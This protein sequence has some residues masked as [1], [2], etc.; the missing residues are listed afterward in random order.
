[1]VTKK[2]RLLASVLT[3][4]L[5]MSAH[6]STVVTFED[7]SPNDLTDG[8]GG[9]LGWASLGGVGIAD[10]DLGGNGLKTFYG[11]EGMVSFD[12]S[13]VVF[14]GTYYKAYA[15]PQDEFPLT[16]IELWYQGKMVHSLQYLRSPLGLEWLA[17]DYSGLVDKIYFRGGFEGF[18]IDDL[19]YE[20]VSAVPLPASWMMFTGGLAVLG[21]VRRRMSS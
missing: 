8:Y 20:A 16:A 6:A 21:F 18:S 10:K 11:H 12:H 15:V 3:L 4:G 9:I 17:S 1:M 2:Q 7:I 5:S 19:T 14:Q 13:P